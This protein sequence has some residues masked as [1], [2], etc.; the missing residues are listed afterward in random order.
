MI[1][2]ILSEKVQML[3]KK[4]ASVKLSSP[5]SEQALALSLALLRYGF[6]AYQHGYEA[7]RFDPRQTMAGSIAALHDILTALGYSSVHEEVMKQ[8][9]GTQ[10]LLASPASTI[11]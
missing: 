3:F 5:N 1:F 7:K 9:I 10:L 2:K 8:C 4:Q 11:H 6:D